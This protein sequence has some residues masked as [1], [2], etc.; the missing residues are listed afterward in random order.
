MCGLH[1]GD[2]LA[3]GQWP[4]SNDLYVSQAMA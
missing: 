2:A 1:V 3:G 4:V